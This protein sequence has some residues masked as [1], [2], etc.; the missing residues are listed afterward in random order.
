[1]AVTSRNFSSAAD[2]RRPNTAD[3]SRRSCTNFGPRPCRVSTLS[4]LI[5]GCRRDSPCVGTCALTDVNAPATVSVAPAAAVV[6]PSA[7]VEHTSELGSRIP[8]SSRWFTRNCTCYLV[9]HTDR[10][11]NT[12]TRT[13]ATWVDAISST[14]CV[15]FPMH[16]FD[17]LASAATSFRFNSHNA[18]F[19]VVPELSRLS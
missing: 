4:P 7:V 16:V 5:A 17:S 1:M 2:R 18:A 14:F 11:T 12:R 9:T 19:V 6:S 13:S 10:R 3:R 15:R 8:L